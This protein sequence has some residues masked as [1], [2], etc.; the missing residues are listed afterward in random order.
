ML[1]YY[2]KKIILLFWALWWLIALWTDLV[3]ALAHLGFLQKSWAPDINYPF[4][5][6]S[7]GIYPLP[8]WFPAFLFSTILFY[9]V[10]ICLA[11]LWATLALAKQEAI[12]RK[13]ADIAFILSLSFWFAFF[14]GDQFIMKYDLEQNHMVQGGLQLLSY[15]CLYCLPSDSK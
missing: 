8:L 14:L 15:L 1:T 5:V 12:W 6:Q 3:G 7:L 4:L 11:F 2:F 13:R 10:L 9:L